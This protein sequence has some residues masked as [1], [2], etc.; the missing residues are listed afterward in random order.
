[1][2]DRTPGD[3]AQLVLVGSIAIAFI[4]LGLVVVFNTVLFTESIATRGPVSEVEDAD[5]FQRQVTDEVPELIRAVENGTDGNTEFVGDVDENVSTTYSRLLAETYAET[6]PTYVDVEFDEGESRFG[7]HV[8]QDSGAEYSSKEGSDWTAVDSYDVQNFTMEVSMSEVSTAGTDF[9]LV[10]SDGG[11]PTRVEMW[12]DGSGELVVNQTDDGMDPTCSVSGGGTI[13][14]NVSTGTVDGTPC[15]DGLDT[16][17]APYEI[18]FE[19]GDQ[20]GGDYSFSVPKR[21]SSSDLDPYHGRDGS[22][23]PYA[24]YYVHEANLDLTYESGGVSYESNQTVT[25]REGAP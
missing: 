2:N 6:G 19:N 7:T 16:L 10:L 23:S 9:A 4:V 22:S 12:K 8:V 20:A 15:F 11:S 14:M 24:V 3:R 1:M 25:V 5:E 17:S 18:D 13:R 21:M